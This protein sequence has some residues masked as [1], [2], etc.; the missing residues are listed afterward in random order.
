MNK[1]DIDELYEYKKKIYHEHKLKALFFEVTSRCNA[2]CEH[3]G[4]S[5]GDFVP[6]DEITAEEIKGVLDDVAEN[7]NP[8][9]IML[10]ITGGE[11]LVRKDLFEI[12]N[13]A[14][15]LGFHWGMTTNGILINEKIVKKMVETNMESVSVSIDGLKELH[16]TF[17]RVPG[18]FDKIIK[19][20]DL[21]GA[22]PSI[23]DLQVTTCVN[24]KNI[25]QLEE[26]Y[27]F[28]RD[29]GVEDWRLIEVDPIGRAK[30]NKD[31]LLDPNDMKR[32]IKFIFDKR[33]E[34]PHM[35]IKYGCGHFLTNELD[36]ALM[37]NCFFCYTGYW[38]ASIYSNGDVGGCPDIERRPELIQGNIR[39]RKF[40]DI[41]EK[42]FKKFRTIY[43][44]SNS[45][46]KKCPDWKSCC[47]DAFHTWDWNLNKPLFCS[48]ELFKE[49]FDKKG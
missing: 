22:C 20:L 49:D 8:N 43:R 32:L 44:T 24:K 6:R 18:S 1:K 42:E 11:P 7:Y 25:D 12:M 46:C 48:R 29:L 38:V 15:N 13:Y 35:Y 28:L 30:D 17:R 3:C 39:K 14:K 27:I 4:S 47:G 16:E 26:L 36:I 37:G 2:K 9:E 33:K 21:M 5:C 34:N 23:L 40:S 10:F 19:G 31:L 41:W 45:K